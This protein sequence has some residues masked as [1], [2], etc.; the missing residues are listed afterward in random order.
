MDKRIYYVG[1]TFEENQESLLD[2]LKNVPAKRINIVS[3][4]LVREASFLYDKRRISSPSDA[5]ELGKGFLEESD[6]EQLM[7]CC[8][9]TKNQ[10]LA[11]NVVSI[12][13]L[14]SSLV[15]PREIFKAA[16]LCNSAGIILFHNH[17]SGDPTPSEEDIIA[18]ARIKEC[19]KL[20]GIELLDHIIV[21]NDTF[22]SLKDKCFI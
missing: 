18:T 16:I 10:P 19:G 8:L 17:P 14:N 3:V 13:T 21:G 20:L 7:V 2:D 6:R 5:Y 9:D 11:I 12:G 1:K 15:H 22:C 4:K